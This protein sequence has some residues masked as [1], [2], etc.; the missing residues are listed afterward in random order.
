[1]WGLCVSLYLGC[2]FFEVSYSG[3]VSQCA[4]LFVYVK[5]L[6]SN[7]ELITRQHIGVN[8][9]KGLTEGVVLLGGS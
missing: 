6:Y 3:S 7:I 9:I 5:T 4:N 1:M 2:Q 8:N